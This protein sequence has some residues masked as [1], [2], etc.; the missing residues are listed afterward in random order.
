LRIYYSNGLEA[1]GTTYESQV[2]EHEAL[3]KE[4]GNQISTLTNIVI[5]RTNADIESNK[6]NLIFS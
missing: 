5:P 3:L 4:L 6:G 2:E 1:L